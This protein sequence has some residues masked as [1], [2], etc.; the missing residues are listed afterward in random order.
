MSEVVREDP[1]TGV[2]L[3]RINR[4][5]ALNA[6]NMVTREVLAKVASEAD[7]DPSVRVIIITG[8]ARAF[9]AGADLKE[10]RARTVLD[11]EFAGSRAA[12]SALERC[13]KPLIAKGK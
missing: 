11:A 10:L 6:L 8:S 4:P 5:E 2:A 9:A 1:A 7:R 3:L 13:R 12:W